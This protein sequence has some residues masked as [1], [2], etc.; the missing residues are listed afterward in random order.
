MMCCSVIFITLITKV[1]EE[2]P[3]N[4]QWELFIS[5]TSKEKPFCHPELINK[6]VLDVRTS[7]SETNSQLLQWI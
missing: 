6:F 4:K 2:N 5:A 7:L 3:M 1:A